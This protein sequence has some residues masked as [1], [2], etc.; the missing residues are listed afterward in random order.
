MQGLPYRFWLGWTKGSLLGPA[1]LLSMPCQSDWI[2]PA[3]AGPLSAWRWQ[4]AEEQSGQCWKTSDIITN[5]CMIRLDYLSSY[6]RWGLQGISMLLLPRLCTCP[7]MMLKYSQWI[8]YVV[9][10]WPTG[11]PVSACSATS[12]RSTRATS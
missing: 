2:S 11:A 12:F 9:S 3:R 10:L 6:H 5:H 1:A 4:E 7:C 8:R